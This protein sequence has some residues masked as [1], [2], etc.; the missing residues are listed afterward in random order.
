MVY[1]CSLATV[2]GKAVA[3]YAGL[4]PLVSHLGLFAGCGLA[5]VLLALGA[6]KFAERWRT[7]GLKDIT[8]LAER[9]AALLAVRLGRIGGTG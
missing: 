7:V 9:R 5:A 6:G 1:I 8:A 4:L 2:L 3:W